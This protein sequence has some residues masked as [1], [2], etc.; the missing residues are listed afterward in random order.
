MKQLIIGVLKSVFSEDV[1]KAIVLALGDHLVASSK[2]RLDDAV[3]KKV[4]N[5]LG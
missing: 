4:R 1:L 2:N 5:K 3:W